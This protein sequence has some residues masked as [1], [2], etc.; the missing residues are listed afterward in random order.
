MVRR[1]VGTYRASSSTTYG[2]D[3]I[4]RLASLSQNF[5]SGSANTTNGFDYNPASQITGLNRSNAAYAF[6][7]YVAASNSYAVNGLNQYTAV[8]AGSLGYEANGNLAATGGTSFRY[9][10]EN[11]LVTAAGTLNLNLVYDPLGRLWQT[12]GGALGKS[13]FV[14]D[15]DRMVA[16]YDGDT[17]SLRRRF[18]FGP[19][20]DEPIL[21][22]E[23]SAMNCAATKVLHADQ[24]GSIVALADCSGTRWRSTAT[25]NMAC[26]VRAIRAGSNIP[27]RR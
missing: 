23:G 6:T 20:V 27:A 10:V 26:R 21:W 17:G 15:G 3:G 1:R 2:Y 11:R 4:S 16:E 8:G 22:D 7:G 25:M 14:Y 12:S 24:Q 19:G 9:D 5:V 18:A 13:Q